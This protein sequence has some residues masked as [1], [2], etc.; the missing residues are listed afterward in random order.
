[1]ILNLKSSLNQVIT[2]TLDKQFKIKSIQDDKFHEKK[3][4]THKWQYFFFCF[5]HVIYVLWLESILI[6][7]PFTINESIEDCEVML[8]Y[9]SIRKHSNAF[10]S[11][12]FSNSI[13]AHFC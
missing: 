6:F 5:I 3:N 7:F 2:S 12:F 1:M 13:F 11:I 10:L 9:F 4:R 8:T